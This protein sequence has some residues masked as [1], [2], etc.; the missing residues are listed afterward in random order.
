[1][2][3]TY[4]S[5]QPELMDRLRKERRISIDFQDR[6]R[7][8][9]NDNYELYRNKIKTNRLTQRQISNIPLLKET[10][11]TLLSQIDEAPMVEFADKAGDMDKSIL[12]KEKWEKF[13]TDNKLELYDL[14]DK[15]NVLLYGRSFKK[16]NYTDRATVSILDIYDIVIDPL[17][18]P[19]NIESAKFVIHQNIYKTV[20]QILADERYDT[21]AK[22]ELKK[23]LNTSEAVIQGDINREEA[24]DRNKRLIT[25]GVDSSDFDKFGGGDT[26]IH[27]CEHYSKMWNKTTKK[28]EWRVFVYGDEK[29][30]LLNESLFDLIGVD[31]LPFCT[32]CEDIETQD[33]WNDSVA[34]TIRTPNKIINTWF[35]QM[36]ENRTLKNFQMHWYDATASDKYVP[37]TYEPGQGRMLPAPGDPSKT[38]KPVDVSG[39]E[40]TMAQI[41]YVIKVCERATGATAI[42]KGTGEENKMT[43]GEVEILVGKA[44]ERALTMSVFYRKSWEEFARKWL[45][46]VE[47]NEGDNDFELL[48]KKGASGKMY[49]KKVYKKDWKSDKGYDIS[50]A[51]SAEQEG[52]KTKSVQRFLLL[53]NYFPDNLPLTKIIQKKLFTL[54]DLT[55]TEIK[56]VQEYEDKKQQMIQEGNAQEMQGLEQSAGNL[57]QL[58]Q[59][60]PYAQP[61]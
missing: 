34:D 23:Y 7:Q 57:K 29:V 55:P 61:A 59:P 47:A 25:M 6:R 20:R 39:L 27:I 4:T 37:Q 8:D 10:V 11:K 45:N 2:E 50:V 36:T 53:K 19:F 17:T 42:S 31:E 41:E 58:L 51:S 18:N 5:P 3:I 1:M 21:E 43:L 22:D 12:L 14:Q 46:L 49:E 15:K 60:Q 24:E 32:W 56:E 38:I 44:Q 33:F 35:S 54:V 48:N 9:W 13:F 16:L 26:L 28:F 52:E 40:D 30:L